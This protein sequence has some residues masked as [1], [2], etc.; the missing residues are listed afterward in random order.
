MSETEEFDS[1]KSSALVFGRHDSVEVNPWSRGVSYAVREDMQP[2][3][4]SDVQHE[5]DA[6]DLR[7]GELIIFQPGQRSVVE[8]GISMALPKGFVGLVTPRSGL[9]AR[10]GISVLNSPGLI[11]TGYRGDIGVILINHGYEHVVFEKGDRI[12]QISVFAVNSARWRQV[13]EVDTA[14]ERGNS[15]FGST[16]VK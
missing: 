14:T 7:A 10:H 13:S 5:G 11:D 3:Y 1:L 8:T 6:F 2:F 12:A 15:G 16:G 9:A 4:G